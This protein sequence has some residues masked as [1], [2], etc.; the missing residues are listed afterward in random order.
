[1]H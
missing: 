1:C